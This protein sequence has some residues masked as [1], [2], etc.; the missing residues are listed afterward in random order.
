[1]AKY[2]K[3]KMPNLHDLTGLN[4][5]PQ[6]TKKNLTDSDCKLKLN[7]YHIEYFLGHFLKI[8]FFIWIKFVFIDCYDWLFFA[9]QV[10]QCPFLYS[11]IKFRKFFAMEF[12][13][14]G[15]GR[16]GSKYKLCYISV[17]DAGEIGYSEANNWLYFWKIYTLKFK[18]ICIKKVQT[19]NKSRV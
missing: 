18:S 17:F 12:W 9:G 6:Q 2:C 4:C 3:I 8:G 13:H 10:L 5:N 16:E 1:M 7:F 14:G 19:L 15:K 11:A